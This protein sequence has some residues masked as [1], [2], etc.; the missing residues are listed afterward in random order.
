MSI[1]KS[2]Q[3]KLDQNEYATGVFVD[4]RKAFDTV[5]YDILIDRLEY[6]GVKGLKREQFCSYLKNRKQFVSIDGFVS[7][8]KRVSTGVPQG[9]LP[10]PLLF[11]IY[12]NDLHT[13]AKYSKT[14]Y[15]A[16][17]INILYS[18]KYSKKCW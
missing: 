2:I 18:N 15:F 13:C 9:S 5:D 4:L 16:D 1:I 17:D 10:G 3:N 7:N 8:N 11:L 12:I 6:Y 14:Y